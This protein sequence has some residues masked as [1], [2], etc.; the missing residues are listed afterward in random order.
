MATKWCFDR[1]KIYTDE[2][3]FSERGLAL[4]GLKMSVHVWIT[5]LQNTVNPKL[6]N[7]SLLDDFFPDNYDVSVFKSD[8]NICLHYV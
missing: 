5:F 3:N 7:S 8:D 4:K 2:K 1:V 6:C